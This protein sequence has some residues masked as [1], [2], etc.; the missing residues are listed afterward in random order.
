MAVHLLNKS[1][2]LSFLTVVNRTSGQKK[3][4]RTH[5]RNG[6][7]NGHCGVRNGHRNGQANNRSANNRSARACAG[8]RLALR[9]TTPGEEGAERESE[10]GQVRDSHRVPDPG[11][12]CQFDKCPQLETREHQRLDLLPIVGNFGGVLT[13]T[14][15]GRDPGAASGFPTR[16]GSPRARPPRVAQ[17]S[18]PRATRSTQEWTPRGSG[19]SRH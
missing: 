11:Q 6:H 9:V 15:R 12:L 17:D 2:V 13:R 14:I 4:R 10:L 8:P 18:V 19:A 3:L 16:L 5:V 1:K 7:R